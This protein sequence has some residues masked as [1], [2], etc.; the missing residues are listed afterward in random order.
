MENPT[1]DSRVYKLM[2]FSGRPAVGNQ[3]YQNWLQSWQSSIL[4]ADLYQVFKWN[5]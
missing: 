2:N 5:A 1:V 4:A 3:C